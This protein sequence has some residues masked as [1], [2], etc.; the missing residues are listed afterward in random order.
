MKKLTY[1]VVCLIVLSG[2]VFGGE[3][4]LQDYFETLGPQAK[5]FLMEATYSE[6]PAVRYYAVK[7]IGE[8]RIKEATTRL[9][10]ILLSPGEMVFY[11]AHPEW[12][13]EIK[14]ISIWAL[15]LIGDKKSISKLMR[16][17]ETSS[18]VRIR[19]EVIRA[20]ANFK[21]SPEVYDFFENIAMS[22]KDMRIV[23]EVVRAFGVLKNPKATKPL[24]N[25]ITSNQ[26]PEDV[27]KLAVSVLQKLNV[28]KKK[29]SQK[30]KSSE[31]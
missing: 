12:E 15:G 16:I 9:E 6:N 18:D 11:K 29:S 2:T 19:V 5:D 24:L 10:D 1:F 14:R 31:K 7:R 30:G 17:Y 26:V 8:L 23:K 27:K 4:G 28:S 3:G 25:L 21:N 13:V 20:L 22:E